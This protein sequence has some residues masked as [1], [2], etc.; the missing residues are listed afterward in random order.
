MFCFNFRRSSA[1]L[2]LICRTVP[3]WA[4]LGIL[5]SERTKLI[6]WEAPFTGHIGGISNGLHEITQSRELRSLD[7]PMRMHAHK[8]L[9]ALMHA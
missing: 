3:K 5:G 9:P 1:A 8:R 2:G 4:A 7:V 6:I